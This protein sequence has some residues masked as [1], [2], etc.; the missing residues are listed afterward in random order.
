MV[1]PRRPAVNAAHEPPAAFHRGQPVALTL[2]FPPDQTQAAVRLFYRRVNQAETWRVA[3]MQLADGG[4]WRAGIPG[5][6]SDSA[7]PLQYYFEP[8]DAAGV[9]WLYP[10]LGNALARQPYYVLRQV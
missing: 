3:P 4:I 5:D 8:T 1:Q 9:P 6:Y 2:A 7:Y 10:G